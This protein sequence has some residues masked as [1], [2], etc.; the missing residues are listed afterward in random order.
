MSDC[1]SYQTTAKRLMGF[2]QYITSI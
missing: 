2:Y 1:V